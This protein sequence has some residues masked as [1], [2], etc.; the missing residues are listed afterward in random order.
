MITLEQQINIIIS[1]GGG[2]PAQ[3]VELAPAH[4]CADGC[5]LTV[6]APKDICPDCQ[7]DWGRMYRIRR[8]TGRCA[9]G[10]E[11]DGG[12]RWH[13]IN[14]ATHKSLCGAKP[15][16]RSNGWGWEHGDD[17]TCPRCLAVIESAERRARLACK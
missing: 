1:K 3:C 2:D 4:H 5:G 7:Q 17:V 14:P 12:S 6:D 11:R 8:L 10:A 13:A 16:R 15:G 9:N